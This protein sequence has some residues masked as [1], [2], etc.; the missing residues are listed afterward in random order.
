MDSSVSYNTHGPYGTAPLPISRSVLL[1]D[2]LFRNYY[3]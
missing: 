3:S 1:H 2:L